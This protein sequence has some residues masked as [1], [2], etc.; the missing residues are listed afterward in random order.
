MIEQTNTAGS[1]QNLDAAPQPAT[2]PRTQISLQSLFLCVTYFS[3][4]SFG[5]VLWGTGFYVIAAGIFLTWLSYR[6]YLWWLHSQRNRT[7]A[8]VLSWILFGASLA[9]PAATTPGCNK[10]PTTNRGWEM[11]FGGVQYVIFLGEAAR[12]FSLDPHAVS[13]KDI[14]Q[15]VLSVVYVFLINLPNLMMLVSPWLFYRQQRANQSHWSELWGSAAVSTWTWS[16]LQDYHMLAGYYLWMAAI[17]L[18]L[19]CRPM[20]VR[21]MVVMGIVGAFYLVAYSLD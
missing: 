1:A 4:A 14:F 6:G 20:R 16:V 21:T 7:R 3:V 2:A 10:S 8:F 18:L 13:P 11:A 19:L 12:E 17:L 9:L 5:A 15:A